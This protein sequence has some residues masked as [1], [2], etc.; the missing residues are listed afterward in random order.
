[1]NAKQN[2]V[3]LSMG[4]HNWPVFCIS[5]INGL[6]DPEKEQQPSPLLSMPYKCEPSFS[7]EKPE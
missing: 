1:M 5:K 7:A 2:Q 3:L 6:P 4:E